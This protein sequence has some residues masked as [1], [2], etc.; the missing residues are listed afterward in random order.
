MRQLK[1]IFCDRVLAIR[2]PPEAA[3]TTTYDEAV[4]VIA[5][6]IPMLKGETSKINKSFQFDYSLD[7]SFKSFVSVRDYRPIILKSR[8]TN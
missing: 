1:T 8:T 6:V 5:P 2:Q 3:L 4:T 7:C